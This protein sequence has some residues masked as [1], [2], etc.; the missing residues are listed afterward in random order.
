MPSRGTHASRLS[1]I[2]PAAMLAL[3]L[4]PAQAQAPLSSFKDCDACPE[5]VTLP[6]DQGL[7]PE[8]GNWHFAARSVRLVHGT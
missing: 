1:G 7:R 5:M 3:M 8:N 6:Y 4:S 2:A